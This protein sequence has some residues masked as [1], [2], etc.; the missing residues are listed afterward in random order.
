MALQPQI[1]PIDFGQ[2]M[3]TKTDPQ[4]L[5]AG[6]MQLLEN[7]RYDKN[8]RISKRFG[9][10]AQGSFPDSGWLSNIKAV[11]NSLLG[12]TTAASESANQNLATQYIANSATWQRNG[13]VCA[14]PSQQVQFLGG[15]TQQTSYLI[16]YDA[17]S[18]GSVT[19]VVKAARTPIL[20][21]DNNLSLSVIDDVTDE[22]IV[23]DFQFDAAV[24]CKVLMAPG[25]D[26]AYI[27]YVGFSTIVSQS[28]LGLAVYQISTKTLT[29]KSTYGTPLFSG[30]ASNS[31]QLDAVLQPSGPLLFIA[32]YNN[33]LGGNNVA[34][35]RIDLTTFAITV[36]NN[37]RG[38]SPTFVGLAV[39]QTG[40][41]NIYLLT[42]DT[43][44]SVLYAAYNATTLATVKT[45]SAT[46]SGLTLT[47]ASYGMSI[48][49]IERSDMAGI[50]VFVSGLTPGG[51]ET[52]GWIDTYLASVNVNY[53]TQ[54]IAN[55]GGLEPVSKPVLING[56]AYVLC[57]YTS[58]LQP[59]YFLVF[60]GVIPT[61][62]QA[63]TGSGA[64][65]SGGAV[66]NPYWAAI[67]PAARSLYQTGAG[68]IISYLK[69][70]VWGAVTTKNLQVWGSNQIRCIA[71]QSNYDPT[72]NNNPI[73]LVSLRYGLDP[74]AGFSDMAVGKNLVISGGFDLEF[75][76]T[77][78]YERGFLTFPELWTATGSGSG[79]TIAA[80]TYL[81]QIV[82][83]WTDNSGQLTQSETSPQ[84][85]I[86]T[87][88]ST[89]SIAITDYGPALSMRRDS[90]APRTLPRIIVYCSQNGGTTMYRAMAFTGTSAT[91]TAI[92]AATNPIIY[93]T[94]GIQDDFT[95]DS[96]RAKCLSADRMVF[97]DPTDPSLIHDGKPI[98]YGYSAS[99]ASGN[100]LRINY[101]GG[102][103][104]ALQFMDQNII[105]SKARGLFICYGD[106]PNN[107]GQ[108]STRTNFQQI[109]YEAGA[110]HQDAGAIIPQGYIFMTPQKGIWL[111][112][113][114]LS[115]SYI[116]APVDNY[117]T[118][119]VRMCRV[120]S[121][122]NQV[123]FLCTDGT[124]IVY[125]YLMPDNKFWYIVPN[126]GQTDCCIL[127]GTYIFARSQLTGF[128]RAYADAPNIFTDAHQPA[129]N[130]ISVLMV[131]GWISFAGKQGFQTLWRTQF[132]GN[133][134][135]PHTIQVAIAY[136]DANTGGAPLF[137][138]FHTITSGEITS[139][140]G[141]ERF[142]VQHANTM[143][144]SVCYKISEILPTGEGFN[145]TNMSVEVGLVPGMARLRK[146][147]RV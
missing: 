137:T 11:G 33:T 78:C 93:D 106:G 43:T 26:F 89:S 112:G 140:D 18:N 24:A 48:S 16:D 47:T 28:F 146:S 56:V 90:P 113:R 96:A 135:S 141:V 12:F 81:L 97:S 125:D 5:Q 100:Q 139:Q 84:K 31:A 142:E 143:C 130:G 92:P 10:L 131:T 79:G 45:G 21:G 2:G 54:N 70:E 35:Y 72:Y 138:E 102:A 133:F 91:L 74:T 61:P 8:G 13:P 38:N 71:G 27:V 124:L 107:L 87:T 85:T 65:T 15:S 127:N 103:V 22:T 3:D 46:P 145:L 63:I 108:G 59:S 105:G 115:L 99:M 117:K 147:K 77:S 95:P 36:V 101:G 49:A 111:L 37:T 42:G 126:S 14:L 83:E 110:A 50:I 20:T 66:T 29:I 4:N 134:L 25:S 119:S 53:T 122:L 109:S 1:I 51:V 69:T 114:D 121:D 104:T 94:G 32:T 40:S 129:P 44:D 55:L 98:V 75:D 88:G 80:G 67:L 6:K 41:N 57:A 123:R 34:L 136:D 144:S 17:V 82:Y 60:A 62:V 118:K 64:P 58:T 7:A 76:G 68:R 116:G 86:T 132:R 23:N 30:G 120:V 128:S 39:P 73:A 19:V 52:M 9:T